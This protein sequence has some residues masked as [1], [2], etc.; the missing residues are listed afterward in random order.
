MKKLFL[1]SAI[2]GFAAIALAGQAD[3][4]GCIKGAIV[5]GIVGHFAGHGGL[6]AA[7]GCAYGIHRGNS[8]HRQD[9]YEGRSSYERHGGDGQRNGL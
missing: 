3:A 7:A 4:R 8:Y 9:G 1:V 2:L 6:G 5:G